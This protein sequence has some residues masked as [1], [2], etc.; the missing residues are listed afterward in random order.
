MMKLA[1]GT[2]FAASIG[3]LALG[4]QASAEPMIYPAKG[5]SQTQQDKDRYEC[6]TWAVKQTGFDPSNPP[7]IANPATTP[8]HGGAL[9]GAAGGAAVG[10]AAGA[11][12]GDAGR[13]AAAGAAGG[14]VLGGLRQR[15][16]NR[17]AAQEVA[18]EESAVTAERSQ[19]DRAL[20]ACMEGRGYTV[21]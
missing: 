20:G 9:R 12:A 15:A 10:A 11:V 21:K 3:F 17:E 1:S 18:K 16:R 6:H 5:Q 7:P 19:Y 2:L 4:L 8:Q 14:A 13:G